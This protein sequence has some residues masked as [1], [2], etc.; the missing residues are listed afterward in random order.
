MGKRQ[1]SFKKHLG[2][3]SETQFVPKPPENNQKNHISGIFQKV[4]WGSG[5]LVEAMLTS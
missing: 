3:I 2:K 5:A 4:E 1:S